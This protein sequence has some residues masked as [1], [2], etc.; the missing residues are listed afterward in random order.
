MI[1]NP[2][3]PGFNPDPSICRV[4]DDYYIA[5]STFEWFPGVQ[6]HH[7]RDLVNWRLVRRPLERA[8]QLDLRGEPDSCGVRSVPLP[9]RRRVLARLYRRQTF[10]WRLQGR[11]QL[12]RHRG[13]DRGAVVGPCLRQLNRFRSV[14]VSR[15]R[16]T[17]MVPQ[18]GLEPSR[19]RG[20]PSQAPGFF[21]RR[22]AGMGPR[23][24]TARRI[25][26]KHLRRQPARTGRRPASLQA[27]R[28][29][30]FDRRR[31][32]DRLRSRCHGALAHDPPPKSP[33]RGTID[34]AAIGSS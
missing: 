15:R 31:R 16:W 22:A 7:S 4:G 32:R 26:E 8:S 30:L 5:T 24:G 20:R 28:V 21:R 33:A 1:R 17:Q 12:H 10:R 18:H 9:R 27:R 14:A 34:H 3:L 11:G 29:V 2:I 6:I 25:S 19:P 13:G 23:R